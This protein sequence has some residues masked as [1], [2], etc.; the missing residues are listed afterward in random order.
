M[1]PN[2]TRSIRKKRNINLKLESSPVVSSPKNGTPDDAKDGLTQRLT[3][4][5][6][7]LE[8]RLDLKAEDL[9]HLKELGAGNGGTVSQVMHIT[10][11]TVMAKK[12]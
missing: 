10:T 11:K 3:D 12:V 7:G 8:F 9:M 2:A 6:V 5:E 1:L 4:L